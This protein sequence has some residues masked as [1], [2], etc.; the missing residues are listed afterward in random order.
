[1]NEPRIL[2]GGPSQRRV[3]PLSPGAKRRAAELHEEHC[4]R[5]SLCCAREW[6]R[7]RTRPPSCLFMGRRVYLMAAI[8][9]SSALRQQRPPAAT[10]GKLT[11]A[12]G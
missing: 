11:A 4:W 7:R 10:L 5:L 1:M 6:C 8:T 12:L 2:P 3:S 9:A